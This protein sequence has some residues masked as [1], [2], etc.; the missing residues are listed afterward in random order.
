MTSLRTLPPYRTWLIYSAKCMPGVVFSGLETRLTK[1]EVITVSAFESRSVDR[2]H[3]TA[4]APTF[5]TAVEL[6]RRCVYFPN[7]IPKKTVLPKQTLRHGNKNSRDPR[8]NAR[9]QLHLR[10]QPGPVGLLREVDD[11]V[12]AVGAER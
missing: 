5:K 7:F 12:F 3:L 9:H 8:V 2:K 11:D 6:L 10:Q 1:V 4:I